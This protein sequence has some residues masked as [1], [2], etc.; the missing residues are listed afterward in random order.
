MTPAWRWVVVALAGICAVWVVAPASIPIYDGPGFPDEPY[1]YVA[2]PAGYRHTP[3]PTAAHAVMRVQNGTNATAYANS[4]ESGPQ[5]SLLVPAGAMAAPPGA[6]T[7]TVDAVP[8]AP[9]GPPPKGGRIVGNVYAITVTSPGGQVDLVGAADQQ[10]I[11]QMRAPTADQPGPVFE[12][13][14]ASGH[15]TRQATTRVG[16]DIY[17]TT[18]GPGQWALVRLGAGAGTHSG[19]NVLWLVVGVPVFVVAGFVL[20]VRFRRTRPASSNDSAS[21]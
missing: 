11:L 4:G 12:A 17:Q 10:P 13:R 5:F 7:I 21:T 14:D 9:T 20:A 15:W 8:L 2:P 19:I 1:R 3:P 18:A 6:T 16:N